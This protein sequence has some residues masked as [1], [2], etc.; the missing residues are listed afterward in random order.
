MIV[1]DTLRPLTGEVTFHLWREDLPVG[2]TDDPEAF[3]AFLDGRAFVKMRDELL[4]EKV[5]HHNLVTNL[6]AQQFASRIINGNSTLQP[7]WIAL[8][9]AVI[10]PDATWTYGSAPG[11]NATAT[12][13]F[14]KALSISAVYQTYYLRYAMNSLTTDWNGTAK[15]AALV[16]TTAG[17]CNLFAVVSCNQSK[18]AAQ[19]LTTEWRIQVRS[20]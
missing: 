13:F 17:A 6:G 12:E 4:V 1:Q 8:G 19:S 10:T 3:A 15:G 7:A 5:V 2:L 11:W 18:T 16:D 14:R 20:P 9:S